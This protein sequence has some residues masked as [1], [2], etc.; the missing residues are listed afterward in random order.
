[1]G[2]FASNVTLPINICSGMRLVA[3]VL[4]CCQRSGVFAR[5]TTIGGHMAYKGETSQTSSTHRFRPR[6]LLPTPPIYI[7]MLSRCGL[8]PR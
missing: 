2:V 4:R 7:H 3:T 8:T 1:M 6:L 5:H